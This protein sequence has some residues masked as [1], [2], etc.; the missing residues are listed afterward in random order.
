[1]N[2]KKVLPL[3]GIISITILV[4]FP[5]LKGGYLSTWDDNLQILYNPDVLN[6]SWLSIKNYFTSFYVHSYQPI[7]SLSFGLEYYFFGNNPL[8]PHITNLVLHLLNII[9][10]FFLLNKITP[11]FKALNVFILAVFAIHPLQGELLGWISTRSTL[12]ANFFVLLSCLYYIKYITIKDWSYK[13]L[14]FSLLFFVLSL[15][16][17]SSVIVLPIVLLSFDYLYGRKLSIVLLLEKT[18]FLVGSFA[19]GIVSLISRN[20]V[21]STS[22]V[23]FNAYYN[24][25]E[26]LSISSQSVFLYLKKIFI[27]DDLGIYYGYPIRI[28]VDGTIGFSFL[29]APLFIVLIAV[30]CWIVYRNI[31]EEHKR[32]WVFGFSFFLINIFI[33]IN[34]ISFGATF[35]AERYLYIG[36][37][38]I[39]ISIS[40]LLHALIKNSPLLEYGV[41]ALLV[42]FLFHLGIVSNDRASI[43]KSD[44]TLWTHVAKFKSQSSYPHKTL[45]RIYEK[46]ENYEKAVNIYNN[47]I[48]TNPYN[49]DLYYWRA[50]VIKEMGDLKYAL[51]DLNRVIAGK[52]KLKGV[53]F[54]QKS[55]LFKQMNLKDSAQISLDSAKY[56]NVQEAMFEGENNP[57]NINRFQQIEKNTLKKIDSL[58][59]VK[60]YESALENYETLT[61]IVPKNIN[62]QLEKGKIESQLQKWNTAIQTFTKILESSPKNEIARLNRAYA[63]FIIKNNI[64]AIADYSFVIKDLRIDRGDIYYF[65]ALAYFNNKQIQLGCRDIDKARKLESIIPSE[66]EDKICK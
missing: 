3:V 9:V 57:L 47:G 29:I 53:A 15:L 45:G 17:K 23:G 7:A 48:K 33:V 64:D 42:V 63:Y 41:Y 11:Q 51:K 4:F 49:I 30:F 6:I 54:H 26:K 40:T 1:M 65:R 21:E 58:I 16:S 52:H 2:F 55:L 24:L 66:I 50:L 44:L 56:Y 61:L 62:Y 8:I 19:I 38:G 36:I 43:W 20:V 18:P 12:V 10:V 59:K 31:S 28:G 46:K 25:Y 37:I 13:Y 14:W 27:T 5:S 60:N 35:F 39:L 22:E 32:L 34:I